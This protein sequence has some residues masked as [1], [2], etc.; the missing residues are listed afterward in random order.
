MRLV[1][2]A[3]FGVFSKSFDVRAA[4]LYSL[5]LWTVLSFHIFITIS[6]IQS[7]QLP[8]TATY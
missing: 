1:R 7:T 2:I 8:N 6:R 4:F 5:I 3:L